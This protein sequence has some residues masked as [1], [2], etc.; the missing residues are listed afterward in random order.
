MRQSRPARNPAPRFGHALLFLPQRRQILLVGGNGYTSSTS[1]QALLYRRLPFEAWT[2]DWALNSWVLVSRA[3][4]EGLLPHPTRE[5]AAAVNDQDE[6]LV[7]TTQQG[8]SQPAATWM[9]NIEETPGDAD[10]VQDFGVPAGTVEYRTGP[11]DPDWYQQDVPAV[12]SAPP[13]RV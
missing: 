2:Y 4:P 12:D 5:L 6:I 11:Y 7:V 8:N 1:Y 9:G 10:V 13:R 3:Q